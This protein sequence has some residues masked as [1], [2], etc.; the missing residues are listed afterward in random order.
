ME[1]S[2]L[3][4]NNLLVAGFNDIFVRYFLQWWSN[5]KNQGHGHI[6]FN[7]LVVQWFKSRVGLL[8]HQVLSMMSA[9]LMT[10]F[11]ALAEAQRSQVRRPRRPTGPTVEG[12]EWGAIVVCWGEGKGAFSRWWQLNDFLVS[13]VILRR[14]PIWLIYILI[15]FKGVETTI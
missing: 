5:L 2:H 12:R 15:F 14:F 6:F 4:S 10:F 8:G 9:L 3:G 7:N 11:F 13:P 1:Q